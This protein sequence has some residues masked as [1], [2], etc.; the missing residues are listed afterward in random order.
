MSL[1][2][3]ACAGWYRLNAQAFD[4]MADRLIRTMDPLASLHARNQATAYRLL[5]QKVEE[6][7]NDR[8]S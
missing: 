8:E 5:A 1:L 6:L 7:D 4:A 2:V 3:A